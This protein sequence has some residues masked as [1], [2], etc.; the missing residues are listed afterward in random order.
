MPGGIADVRIPDLMEILVRKRQPDLVLASLRQKIRCRGRREPLVLV[1][2]QMKPRRLLN[3]P[4]RKDA[5][6]KGT[7]HERTDE[8][9]PLRAQL[10]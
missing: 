6:G 9:A 2:V 4:A 5:I 10:L 1:K 8:V 3:N 7:E